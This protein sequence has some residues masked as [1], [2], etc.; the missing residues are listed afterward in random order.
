VS[1]GQATYFG[2]FLIGSGEASPRSYGPRLCDFFREIRVS[3]LSG[4][5]S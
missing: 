2:P 1:T 4:S 3:A 5:L